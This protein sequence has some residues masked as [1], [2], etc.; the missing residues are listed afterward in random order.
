MNYNC[1]I[2][3][4]LAVHR[5]RLLLDFFEDVEKLESPDFI[6]T[7]TAFGNTNHSPIATKS[8]T[9][10]CPADLCMTKTTKRLSNMAHATLMTPYRLYFRISNLCWVY[11]K[12]EL[13]SDI[14]IWYEISYFL[15][16]W[17]MIVQVWRARQKIV[18]V[19]VHEDCVNRL[20]MLSWRQ[21]IIMS[22]WS[23]KLLSS[24]KQAGIFQKKTQKSLIMTIS[25]FISRLGTRDDILFYCVLATLI[26]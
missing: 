6:T 9:V 21:E 18:R 14:Y 16:E 8:N 10:S 22:A 2:I 23:T 26:M 24:I 20:C 4:I 7:N 1:F 13:A 15:M 5:I 25:P 19:N 17:S 11:R 12:T 3:C